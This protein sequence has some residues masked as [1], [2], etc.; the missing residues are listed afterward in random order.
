ML[1][2]VMIWF[3]ARNVKAKKPATGSGR[4]KAAAKP[5]LKDTVKK[6]PPKKSKKSKKVAKDPED[7]QEEEDEEE[8]EPPPKKVK[9]VKKSK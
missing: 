4:V 9:K 6:S 5:K 8:V 7:D 2:H 1:W 3:T